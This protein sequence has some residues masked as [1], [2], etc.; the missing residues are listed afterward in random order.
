MP[1][2]P[3]IFNA[4]CLMYYMQS[5]HT[6]RRSDASEPR[7]RPDSCYSHKRA[8]LLPSAHRFNA[9]HPE[10]LAVPLINRKP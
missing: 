2:L 8:L 3:L 7:V 9:I 5:R 4:I 1:P 10:V 6:R